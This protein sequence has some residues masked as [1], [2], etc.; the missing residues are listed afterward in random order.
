MSREAWHKFGNLA[1]NID[2]LYP[3]E[4]PPLFQ[5]IDGVRS[6]VV[7]MKTVLDVLEYNCASKMV[8]LCLF[9]EKLSIALRINNDWVI[10]YAPQFNKHNTSH[11]VYRDY[12]EGGV[13]KVAELLPGLEGELPTT[14]FIAGYTW[15]GS[16]PADD[17]RLNR[18]G[19]SYEIPSILVGGREITINYSSCCDIR[20]ETAMSF[21]NNLP[22]ALPV[23]GPCIECSLMAPPNWVS[24]DFGSEKQYEEFVRYAAR[25]KMKMP[26]LPWELSKDRLKSWHSKE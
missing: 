22:D 7:A 24:L 25:F 14:F 10:I 11:L 19:I 1:T 2:H 26:K 9:K 3:K 8:N 16:G 23:S 13:R 15:S 5:K 21:S 12:G 4:T 18:Y 6:N 20:H 17:S